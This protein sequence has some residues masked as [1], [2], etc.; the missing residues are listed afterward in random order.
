MPPEPD[1]IRILDDEATVRHSIDQLLDSDPRKAQS[2][3]DAE[4][5]FAHARRHAVP[6]TLLD[7]WMPET[8]GPAS[9]GAA[10]AMY[11]PIRK[12]S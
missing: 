11:C 2:F 12:W 1:T 10:S 8:S 3:E 6:L 4:V 5:F 7:L 9:A